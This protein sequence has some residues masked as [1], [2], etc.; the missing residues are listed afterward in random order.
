MPQASQGTVKIRYKY[1]EK[2]KDTTPYLT[3]NSIDQ[4]VLYFYFLC[5][6]L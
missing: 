4:N 2:I 6:N 5:S 1:V 3:C